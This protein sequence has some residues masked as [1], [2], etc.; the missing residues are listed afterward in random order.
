MIRVESVIERLCGRLNRTGP[1]GVLSVSLFGSSAVG[2][3]RPNSDIDVLVLTQRSLSRCE[4]QDLVEFLLRFSG[5]RVTVAPGR[6]LEVT[7]LILD[8]VVPWTYPPVCDFLYGEWLRDEFLTG[9]LPER[10]HNP[11][12]AVLITTARQHATC[13]LGPH[14]R[15]LLAP[16]PTEDLH[17]SIHHGLA[18]LLDDLVG[19]E[20]NVLLTLARM[21]VTVETD[22]IL[23]KDQA[24]DL[25]LPSLREPHRSVLFL[26]ARAYVGDLVDEW[27]DRQAEARDTAEHLA[28]RIRSQPLR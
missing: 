21:V 8:D 26:A 12:L 1:G 20:R 13:L 25:I 17:R 7:A 11:D 22:Q 27:A 2:G 19:D 5:R 15:D 28:T 3:L 4:R 16:V 6:P 10:H 9:R 23:P 24:A 18:P 14:P